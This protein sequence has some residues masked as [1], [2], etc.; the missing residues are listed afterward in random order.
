MASG[1]QWVLVEMVQAFYEVRVF[2]SALSG[3]VYQQILLVLSYTLLVSSFTVL[4]NGELVSQEVT[5]EGVD[6]LFSGLLLTERTGY[7]E[8]PNN[9]EVGQP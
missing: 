7:L 2:F 9:K 3:H 8:V 4:D 6:S 5:E 1:Q